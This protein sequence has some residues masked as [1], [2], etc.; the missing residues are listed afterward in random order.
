MVRIALAVAPNMLSGVVT[1]ASGQQR[2][3]EVGNDITTV[4]VDSIMKVAP[5]QTVTDLLET[6]VPGLVV[7]HTSGVPG[8]P[9]RLRLRG[10]G[11]VTL[12][13]DPIVIVDGVRVYAAQSD[14]RNDNLAP[15]QLQGSNSGYDDFT[16]VGG[17]GFAAPSP[18]DQIDPNSIEKVEVKALRRPRS[19]APTRRTASSSLPPSTGKPVLRGGT[20]HWARA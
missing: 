20:S 19:M 3:V 10:A 13:N 14:R 5:I 18:L 16:G 7:Q 15:S 17:S 2:K 8:D 9:S 11:S 6:R 12:S 4:N 1:T